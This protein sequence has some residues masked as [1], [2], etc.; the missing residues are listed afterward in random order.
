VTFD[1]GLMTGLPYDDAQF[2]YILSFNVIY[3]GDKK[4]VAR[5]VSEIRRTLKPGGVYQGTMLSKRNGHFGHGEEISPDTFI[6]DH[7]GT[8]DEA[9]PHYYCNAG[10]LI[11]LFDGFEL[12]SLTDIDHSHRRPGHWHWHMVAERP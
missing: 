12:M 7:D 5:A 1:V 3:H 9:H 10:E 4:T 6:Y 11:A 2:D 8:G